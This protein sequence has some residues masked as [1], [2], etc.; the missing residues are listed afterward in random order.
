[1]CGIYGYLGNKKVSKMLIG[2]LRKLEYRGYDSAGIA[3]VSDSGIVSI[4]RVGNLSELCS[5]YDKLLVE[6]KESFE[7]NCGIGHTRWATHGAVTERNS[8][9][10]LSYD[11]KIAVVHNGTIENYEAIREKLKGKGID[12]ISDTDSEVIAHLIALNMEE[13]EDLKYA[14]VNSV[15]ELCGSWAIAVIHKSEKKIVAARKSSPLIIGSKNDEFFVSSDIPTLNNICTA[16][17]LM[18][19]DELCEITEKGPEFY[20]ITGNELSRKTKNPISLSTYRKAE[21]MAGFDSY[22]EKEICQIP[23]AIRETWREIE[24]CTTDFKKLFDGIKRMVF[25]G[26]G[27]AFHAGMFGA[28][29][30]E[31]KLNIPCKSVVA[32]EFVY[33]EPAIDENTLCFFISQ[34]GET[35]DTLQALRKAK[36]KGAR[37]VA[38]TN[39]ENSSICFETENVIFTRAGEERAVASTKAYN[40]QLAAL[41][42]ILSRIEK[43]SDK[44]TVTD[45]VFSIEQLVSKRDE[46]YEVANTLQKKESLFYIGRG[47]DYITA[48]EGALKLKEI[49]YLYCEALSGGELKHGT[50]ALIH[51][52]I[53][54]IAIVTQRNIADKMKL[55]IEETKARGANVITIS[56]FEG[57]RGVSDTF[58][59]LPELTAEIMPQIAVVPLQL[60][61]YATAKRFG[62]NPD[63]PRNL[64]K[65]V[66]V[67]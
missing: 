55:A 40:A 36:C 67:E 23:L 9:P 61:A 41:Y 31:G 15:A 49:S 3:V 5:A 58:I 37:T 66:T 59:K 42:A 22:M 2:G 54:V 29:V 24:S 26:C 35:A 45:A 50:L 14:V 21:N 11:G 19:E 48:R 53:K 63:M 62:Y 52:G 25:I 46:I 17:Y 39:V 33:S 57:L 10:H 16:V 44:K 6:R 27:T 51:K 28:Q 13:S 47:L 8:H 56:P 18:K 43:Q 7:K 32:S 65:S 60:I 30:Y 64:A 38:I 34:S 12:C 1:M 4:K 20:S